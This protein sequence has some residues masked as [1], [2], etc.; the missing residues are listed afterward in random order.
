M[1]R[2]GTG[3]T[4]RG[5]NNHPRGPDNGR[6][7]EG[8]LTDSQGYELVRAG[9]GALGADSNGYIRKQRV[10]AAAQSGEEAHHKNRNRADNSRG[11]VEA[12]PEKKHKALARRPGAGRPRGS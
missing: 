4:V 8:K 1:P 2:A 3:N 12:L 7:H 5:P 9:V 11:N 6:W 10:V